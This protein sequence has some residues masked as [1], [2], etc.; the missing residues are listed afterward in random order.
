MEQVRT[1]LEHPTMQAVLEPE[2][3]GIAAALYGAL[4][5]ACGDTTIAIVEKA[6][7]GESLEAWRLLCRRHESQTR[8]SK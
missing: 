8:Q 2:A 4:V 7:S 5:A 6:G 1:N 3:V